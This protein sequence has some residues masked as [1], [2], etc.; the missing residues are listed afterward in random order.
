ME[1]KLR[2]K[3][4]TARKC[5]SSYIILVGEKELSKHDPQIK[6]RWGNNQNILFLQNGRVNLL[7]PKCCSLSPCL[8]LRGLLWCWTWSYSSICSQI[9]IE[10]PSRMRDCAEGWAATG[11]EAAV[12][13]RG[14]GGGRSL[15]RKGGDPCKAG[16]LPRRIPS[17][18]PG[19]VLLGVCLVN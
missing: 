15:W 13:M 16:C 17:F 8:S 6:N 14:V 11:G 3:S 19:L 1:E 4:S 9:F 5:W 7:I 12:A 2:N 18:S 10:Q